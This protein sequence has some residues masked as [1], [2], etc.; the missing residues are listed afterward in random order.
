M[1]LLVEFSFGLAGNRLVP[2]RRI[3][4]S[5]NEVWVVLDD[6]KHV[7]IAMAGDQT[8]PTV[9]KMAWQPKFALSATHYP[10]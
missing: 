4:K 1:A 3:V 7:A 5:V 2:V 9:R 8:R 10:S 6:P